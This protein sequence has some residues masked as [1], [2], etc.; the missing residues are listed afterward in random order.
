MLNLS[1]KSRGWH[2]TFHSVVG[3][4]TVLATRRNSPPPRAFRI[5]S[6]KPLNFPTYP[7]GLIPKHGLHTHYPQGLKPEFG[8]EAEAESH[9]KP[10]KPLQMCLLVSSHA[11]CKLA[12]T[13][14]MFRFC[15]CFKL[16]YVGN[17]QPPQ[18]S[19][20]DLRKQSPQSYRTHDRG[21]PMWK[22]CK[23]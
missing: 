17:K 6:R 21:R 10:P 5:G 9:H 11:L 14:Q 1:L 8:L 16:Y 19:S 2:R 3:G 23:S 4:S 12:F 20:P 15:L 13:F 18:V 7:E 22:R